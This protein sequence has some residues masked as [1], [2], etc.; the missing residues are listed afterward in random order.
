MIERAKLESD[1]AN[2]I[3]QREQMLR[4]AEQAQANAM[5]LA[6][7]IG[8]INEKLAELAKDEAARK[9]AETIDKPKEQTIEKHK[10]DTTGSP[11]SSK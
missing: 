1:K 10:R 8:Y 11:T 7:A 4:A 6:G 5:R 2:L 9:V 3:Q